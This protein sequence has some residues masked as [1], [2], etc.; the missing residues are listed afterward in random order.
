M[1]MINPVEWHVISTPDGYKRYCSK[2]NAYIPVPVQTVLG[3]KIQCTWYR[4]KA[5]A[6]IESIIESRS[7]SE[8]VEEES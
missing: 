7:V 3:K 1:T 5:K 8:E 4:W 2:Q 6:T